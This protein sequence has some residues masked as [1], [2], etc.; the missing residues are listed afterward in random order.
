[1]ENVKHAIIYFFFTHIFLRRIGKKYPD[2]FKT[3]IADYV[4]KP[5][6]RQI[7]IMRYTGDQRMTFMAIAIELNMDESALYK[8]HKKAVNALISAE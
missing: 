2:F 6:D 7:L 8:F 1:M 3:W 5:R 4:E